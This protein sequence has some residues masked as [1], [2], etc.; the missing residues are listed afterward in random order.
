MTTTRVM[1]FGLG[2]VGVVA[3]RYLLDKGLVIVGAYSRRQHIGSDLGTVIGRA[4]CG[5]KIAAST[6]QSIGQGS[7]D[8]ALFF[9]TGALEDLLGEAKQCLE[10]GINVLTIAESALFPGTYDPA[11]AAELDRAA[12]AG[13]A[14]LAGTGVTDGIMVHLSAVL[15]G[16]APTVQA[17]EIDCVGDF[18]RLGPAGLNSLPFGIS[19]QEFEAMLQAPPTPGAK[20]PAS[21]SGQGAEALVALLGLTTK[22]LTSAFALETAR[23]D[24]I[25]ATLGRTVS[26]GTIAGL[27]ES[28]TVVTAEGVTIEVR[29]TVKLF[30]AGDEEY[31][32]CTIKG[33][34]PRRTVVAPNPAGTSSR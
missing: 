34:I 24:I 22:E 33:D 26:T 25:V 6:Q 30:E 12:R 13:G 3:A 28:I 29:M 10:A 23:S 4:P 18:A 7:A 2:K 20:P 27:K 19:L 1:I 11:V 17:I 31:L 8:V 9:T 16:C 14:S 15:A 5:V 32:S 21:V